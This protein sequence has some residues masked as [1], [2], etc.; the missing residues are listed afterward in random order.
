LRIALEPGWKEITARD[1]ADKLP[2]WFA[3]A[4]LLIAGGSARR[5]RKRVI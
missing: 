1:V 5:E 4:L 3:L 2:L